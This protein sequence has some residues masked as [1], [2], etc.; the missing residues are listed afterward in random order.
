MPPN[1]SSPIR[2]WLEAL[3]IGIVI[4][5]AVVLIRIFAPND[6]LFRGIVLIMVGLFLSVLQFARSYR[7]RRQNRE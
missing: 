1:S 7:H 6:P 4:G 2:F 3:I 5:V